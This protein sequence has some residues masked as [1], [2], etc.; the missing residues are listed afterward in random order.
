[1]LFYIVAKLKIK[2]RKRSLW[3]C[4]YPGLPE[5]CLPVLERCVK[6]GHIVTMPDQ[7]TVNQY[8]VGQGE[9]LQSCL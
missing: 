5:E 2:I 1:M 7:L 4:V 6:D 8:E 9:L 3:A